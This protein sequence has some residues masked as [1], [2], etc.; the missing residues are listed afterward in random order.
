MT[1]KETVEQFSSYPLVEVV[2]NDKV[3]YNDFDSTVFPYEEEQPFN[4]VMYE[5]IAGLEKLEVYRICLTKVI[6]YHWV[7]RILGEL[8]N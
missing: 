5:R 3:L 4:K 2:Y 8:I 6:G 7:L 1:L